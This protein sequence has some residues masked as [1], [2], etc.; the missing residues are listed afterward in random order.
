MVTVMTEA[1]RKKGEGAVIKVIIKMLQ[2]VAGGRGGW[3]ST[4]GKQR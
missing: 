1:S 2:G 4:V 3:E